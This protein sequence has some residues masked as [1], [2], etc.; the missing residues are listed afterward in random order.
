MQW[1]EFKNTALNKIQS[2]NI[3]VVGSD[4]EWGI[5]QDTSREQ[6]G[7]NVKGQRMIGDNSAAV[8]LNGEIYVKQDFMVNSNDAEVLNLLTH[9]VGHGWQN[10]SVNNL[11]HPSN[12]HLL[13]D[14][15]GRPVLNSEG[16]V[17]GHGG[18]TWLPSGGKS[19]GSD[20]F[21]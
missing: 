13:R 17:S 10:A 16:K 1:E 7:G 21:K 15:A 4:A 9:E 11:D 20:W 12:I 14:N 18:A 5:L 3:H 6:F 19:P 8:N 2:E